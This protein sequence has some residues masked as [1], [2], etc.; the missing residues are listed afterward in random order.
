[1][2]CEIWI[3]PK[4]GE[5]IHNTSDKQC[6]HWRQSNR[7]II[8]ACSKEYILTRSPQ[9]SEPYSRE[10]L[11]QQ[12]QHRDRSPKH[13]PKLTSTAPGPPSSFSSP[14]GKVRGALGLSGYKTLVTPQRLRTTAT[15]HPIE[16]KAF[17]EVTCV[18]CSGLKTPRI[19]LSS[20]TGSPK[21]RLSCLSHQSP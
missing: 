6:L 8:C 9:V 17:L 20:W 21:F 14:S 15:K 5:K 12:P 10:Q 1:M 3:V 11:V 7:A 18:Y 13:H 2:Y 4:V 19:S 16:T